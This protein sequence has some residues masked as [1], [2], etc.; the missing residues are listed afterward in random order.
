VRA[1]SD[2]AAAYT[3]AV[4]TVSVS[5]AGYLEKAR[6]AF[7][8]AL[9]LAPDSQQ[10]LMQAGV[11]SLLAGRDWTVMERMQRMWVD[12]AGSSDYWANYSLALAL[13]N[14]GR[15]HESLQYLQRAV[16]AEP[17]VLNTSVQLQDA[18]LTIGDA[19]SAEAEYE[20]SKNLDENSAYADYERLLAAGQ[21]RHDPALVKRY[22]AAHPPKSSGY[23]VLEGLDDPSGALALLHRRYGDPATEASAVNLALLAQFAAY[24]G[25]PNLA[26]Q[27][28]HKAYRTSPNIFFVWHP[29]YRDMRRLTGF[30]DLMRELRLVDYW[31]GSGN[32]AEFC[33]PLADD[34][35][36]CG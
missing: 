26:L 4:G 18:Y 25:D 22:F 13:R 3:G 2:L 1:W 29:V 17:L 8:H 10:L 14:V 34:D 36:E 31:R 6:S 16:R 12:G 20:R 27:F 33:H 5:D 35:F 19:K 15:P 28:L 32:W 7:S 9:Q 23:P 30:K 11:R 21:D 24:Y